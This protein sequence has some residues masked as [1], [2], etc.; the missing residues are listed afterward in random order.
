MN[1]TQMKAAKMIAAD[2]QE[3]QKGMRGTPLKVLSAK[4]NNYLVRKVSDSVKISYEVSF[5]DDKVCFRDN[6]MREVKRFL[7]LV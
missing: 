1:T 6:A 4:G 3:P 5:P 7:S 2:I